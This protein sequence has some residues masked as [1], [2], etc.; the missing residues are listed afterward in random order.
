MTI[1]ICEDCGRE[2]KDKPPFPEPCVCGNICED[3]YRLKDIYDEEDDKVG[4]PL[5]G[6]KYGEGVLEEKQSIIQ[7]IEDTSLTIDFSK[8]SKEEL[9]KYLATKNIKTDR[10]YSIEKLIDMCEEA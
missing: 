1:F 7:T 9:I 3:F 4:R 5:L 8:L 10:R 6:I 2:Y